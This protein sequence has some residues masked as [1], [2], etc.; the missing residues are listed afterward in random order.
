MRP[1]AGTAFRAAAAACLLLCSARAF[2]DESRDILAD[3]EA[4]HRTNAMQY[5][6][7][8]TVTT[9]DGKVRSK[10]WKSYRQG[11]SAEAKVLIRFTAPPE[12]RGVG[13]LSL[14][15]TGVNADQWLYLPSMKRERR[16]YA[17]DRDTSFVGT[18]F[19][20]EDMEEFD[21]RKYDTKLKDESAVDGA[22]CYVIEARPAKSELATAYAKRMLYLRKDNLYLVREDLYR[23]GD[24]K[25]SKIFLLSRLE[26]VGGHTV[27]LNLMMND[28]RKESKTVVTLKDVVFDMPQPEDRYTLKNLNREGGD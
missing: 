9:K 8:L 18:D 27:A 17:Q 20:Y 10:A 28:L 25:P 21:Y 7:Q 26:K 15:R 6:G 3:S 11:Y 2:A 5:A 14:A 22:P 13:F 12:V 4:R 19:T 1:T 23:E 24:A 16:I